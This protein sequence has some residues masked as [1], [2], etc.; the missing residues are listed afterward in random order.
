MVRDFVPTP[1]SDGGGQCPA[2]GGSSSCTGEL[3][4][5]EVA[6]VVGSGGSAHTQAGASRNQYI[7]LPADPAHPEFGRSVKLKAKVGPASGSPPLN[8]KTIY[9]YF[10]PDGGNRA[11]LTG[12]LKAG[13][14]SAGG[15]TTATSMTDA[16]GWTGC[17]DTL[18]FSIWRR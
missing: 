6:E 2:D 16:T 12:N 7:N 14:N 15:P 5:V 9:F 8:G 1:V 10:K 17:C 13:F 11:G 3:K 4:L 18:P